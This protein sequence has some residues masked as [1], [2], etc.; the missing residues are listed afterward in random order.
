MLGSLNLTQFVDFEHNDWD[1]NKLED[2]VP[3]AIR[4]MDNVNDVTNVPLEIQKENLQNKRRIGLGILGL[5]SALMMMKSRYGSDDSLD[6]IEKLMSFITN[7]AYKTSSYLAKEKG[8]FPLYDEDKY[9]KSKFLKVLSED[10]IDMIKKY[11]IRNSHLQS[12]QPVGNTSSFA[13]VVSSGLEPIFLQQYIR[14]AIVPHQPEG[15]INPTEINWNSAKAENMGNWSWTKEGDTNLLTTTFNEDV[16]KIDQNRGLTKENLVVDYAVKYLKSIGE[17]DEN[18]DWCVDTSKLKI[19]D[20]T[21]TMTVISKY[22]DSAMSKCVDAETSMVIIDDKVYYLDEL[23]YKEEDTFTSYSGKTV[24]HNNMI[25]DIKSVYNNGIKDTLK[26]KFDDGSF[27]S[28]TDT[29]G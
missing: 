21:K 23:N 14:T 25:V 29:H 24:N 5:G 11:G 12:I 10:T 15:L 22:I 2:I 28:C 16:Y 6:K 20:H 19:D 8:V 27:I 13:N 26:I 7:T 18:A 3:V 4:M 9:L 1:Y 17:Y